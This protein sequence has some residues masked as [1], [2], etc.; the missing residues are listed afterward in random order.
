M[1]RS[2]AVRALRGVSAMVTDLCD[3]IVDIVANSLR[4]KA[5]HI[6]VF[7]SEDHGRNRL[8]ITIRDDGNGME[9]ETVRGVVDPFFSTKPGKTVGLGVPLFKGTAEICNGEFVIKS[10]PEKGTEV[11]ASFQLDHP[12]LPPLGDLKNTILVLVVSNP[13][14]DFIFRYTA[15][16][17]DFSLDTK[18]MRDSL[19]SVPLN[20]PEVVTFLRGYLEQNL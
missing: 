19:G 18:E 4:A 8:T 3:H 7:V 15:G 11:S 20:H 12:D 1:Y 13:E 10:I 5:K 2:T 14:T 9:E 16:E 6:G 17:R